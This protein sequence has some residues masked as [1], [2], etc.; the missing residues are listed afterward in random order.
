MVATP[1]TLIYMSSGVS[2]YVPESSISNKIARFWSIS[3]Y[4]HASP[5]YLVVGTW[6]VYNVGYNIRS[7]IS[8]ERLWQASF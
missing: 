8:V 1:R 6:K 2:M 5:R 4:A 7:Y 3:S